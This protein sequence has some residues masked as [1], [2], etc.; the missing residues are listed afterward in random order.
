M[1]TLTTTCCEK[2][3]PA[4][5]WHVSCV[6]GDDLSCCTFGQVTP[7]IETATDCEAEPRF[8]PSI[9]GNSNLQIR[10]RGEER[11]TV[12]MTLD[13]SFKPLVGQLV[14]AEPLCPG[15]PDTLDTC[16]PLLAYEYLHKARSHESKRI[17]ARTDRCRPR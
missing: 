11:Q 4:G 8:T 1:P 9:Y 14:V 13:P 12:R 16:G 15:Q 7:P 10:R 5:S 17:R 2:P 3:T 6:L